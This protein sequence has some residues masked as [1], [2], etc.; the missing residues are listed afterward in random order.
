MHKEAKFWDRIAEKYSRQPIADE[1][2]YRK[3]LEITQS[4]FTPKTELLELGV[5]NRLHSHDSFALCEAHPRYRHLTQH[6]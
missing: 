6:D 1:A 4:Y 5:R 2:A 3:K